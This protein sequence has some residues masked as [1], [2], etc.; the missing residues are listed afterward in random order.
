MF[1]RKNAIK[2][3]FDFIKVCNKRSVS[4]LYTCIKTKRKKIFKFFL[5]L[6]FEF[7]R[8]LHAIAHLQDRYLSIFMQ[9]LYKPLKK[10]L[11]SYICPISHIYD[12]YCGTEN[13]NSQLKIERFVS[14]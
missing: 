11:N 10:N 5:D 13:K 14:F 6:S 7:L 9:Y 3:S 4:K 12:F 1:R 8:I 2:K